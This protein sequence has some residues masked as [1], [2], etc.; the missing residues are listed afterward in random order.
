MRADVTRIAVLLVGGMVMTAALLF[1]T[2][3][4]G[5]GVAAGSL[6]GTPVAASTPGATV[7][8]SAGPSPAPTSMPLPSTSATPRPSPAITP[9]EAPVGTP[10]PVK[11][12]PPPR[13]E[14]ADCPPPPSNLRLAPVLAHGDERVKVVALTFD[15]GFNEANTRRIL[16][17]LKRYHVNATFFPTGRAIAQSPDVWRDVVAAG[18]PIGDHTYS[19]PTLSDLCYAAQLSEIERQART[20][21]S[22]LGINVE[23]YMRPPYE[24]WNRTTRIAITG[25]RQRAM[26]IWNIDTKDWAG[27]TVETIRRR[28]LHGQNGAI[29]LMHTT[30]ENTA[31]AL[32]EII[33]GYR[34]RGFRFVTIGEML[35]LDGPVPYR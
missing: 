4:A 19:H 11:P 7:A 31:I 33:A 20:V 35:G 21:R 1:S 26:V 22:R 13:D 16:G 5:V 25:A 2:W 12:P 15:D 6:L 14:A 27:S 17:I 34:A 23:P 10:I 3:V 9:S 28:A 32:P 30:V 8:A 24:A 29:V 18:F